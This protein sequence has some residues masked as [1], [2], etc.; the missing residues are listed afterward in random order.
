MKDS[1][2]SQRTLV[3]LCALLPLTLSSLGCVSTLSQA[4]ATVRI[5]SER[6]RASCTFITVV[7]AQWAT[8]MDESQD[9]EGAMNEVRNKVAEKGGNAMKIIAMDTTPARTMVTAEALS[10]PSQH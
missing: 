2:R 7:S 6:E 4:G 10:C 5:A 9:A 8:G 3:V 1:G